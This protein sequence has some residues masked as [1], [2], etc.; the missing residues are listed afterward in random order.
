MANYIQKR[1]NSIDLFDVYDSFFKPVF[2]DEQRDLKTNIKESDRSYELEIE[3]PGYKKDQIKLSLEDG[4]LTVS[5]YRRQV[6]EEGESKTRYVRKEISESCQRTYYVGKD[7]T[8]DQI[9]AKY[10][11][12]ILHVTVPKSAPKQIESQY[13]NVE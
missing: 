7:V 10:K 5:C 6:E 13:I 11:D 4:Y 9:K 3:T 8:H 2:L 12:G 1:S